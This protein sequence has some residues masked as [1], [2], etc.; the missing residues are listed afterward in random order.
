MESRTGGGGG[1]RPGVGTLDFT[2]DST[3]SL[4]VAGADAATFEAF[5]DAGDITFDGGADGTF[6]E[7]FQVNGSTL[8]I[9]AVP[10]P[11]SLALIGWGALGLISRRRR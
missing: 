10:E 3:G 8:S 1:A 7:L 9:A 6:S 5:F 11:S 2:A 4:T